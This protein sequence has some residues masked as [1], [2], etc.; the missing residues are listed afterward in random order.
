MGDFRE[1]KGLTISIK[2]ARI[3]RPLGTLRV[4]PEQS[5][6]NVK[7]LVLLK[8]SVVSTNWTPC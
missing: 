2:A 1:G 6:C 8:L 4:L 5:L 7:Q 3:K